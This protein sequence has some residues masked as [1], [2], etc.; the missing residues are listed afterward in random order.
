MNTKVFRNSTIV[1][2]VD[3]ESPP[4][5]SAVL[6]FFLTTAVLLSNVQFSASTARCFGRL[7]GAFFDFLVVDSITGDLM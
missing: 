1:G 7:S 2:K 6:Y 3:V 4:R 5:P